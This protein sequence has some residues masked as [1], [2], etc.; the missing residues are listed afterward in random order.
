MSDIIASKLNEEHQISSFLHQMLLE[1]YGEETNRIEAGFSAERPVTFRA[2]TIKTS[3]EA[4]ERELEKL[5]VNYRRVS[6]YRDAFI[7]IDRKEEEVKGWEIYRKGEIYLQSLSS[8]LPPLYLDAQP[9]ETILDM[10]AAPGGKTTQIAAL[11]QNKSLITACE[12]DKIRFGRLKFNLARQG[13]TRVNAMQID[14]ANLDDYFRFDK[15]LLDAPCS[16]S[17]TIVRNQDNISEKLIS[18]CQRAQ[19]TLLKKALSLLKR[20]GML[21]YSTCSILKGENEWLI[22]R[23]LPHFD[24]KLLPL[25]RKFDEIPLLPGKAGTLTVCPNELFEGFFLAKIQRN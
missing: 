2:N 9:K 18:A 15:I 13:A 16:G 14:A 20:G 10:T 24:C 8:M 12:K 17:G 7:L 22:E 23:V 4:I 11:T 19:E 5:K 6:W 1:Q 25:E 3:S 21:L